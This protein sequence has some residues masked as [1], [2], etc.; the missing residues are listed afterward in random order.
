MTPTEDIVPAAY[1]R[2]TELMARIHELRW[3]ADMVADGNRAGVIQCRIDRM[4]D[5]LTRQ[6]RAMFDGRGRRIK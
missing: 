1:S 6:N 2:Q 4:L 5:G 3:C